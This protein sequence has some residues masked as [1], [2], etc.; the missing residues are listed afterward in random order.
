[1]ACFFAEDITSV[2]EKEIQILFSSSERRTRMK[3]SM[4]NANNCMKNVCGSE[5]DQKKK[6]ADGTKG[7]ATNKAKNCMKESGCSNSTKEY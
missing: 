5:H 7:A 2:K 1:M 6:N 3:N 4:K